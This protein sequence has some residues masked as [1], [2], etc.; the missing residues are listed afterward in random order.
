MNKYYKYFKAFIITL[1]SILVLNLFVSILYY[2][3]IFNNKELN[4]TNLIITS[5][6]MLIGGIYIGN[7]TNK[8]GYLEGLKVGIISIIIFLIISYLAFDKVINIK[9]II[10]YFILLISSVLGS[11][12]GINKKKN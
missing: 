4:Y 12:I 1:F 10:F 6:S 5:I 8:K 3:N 7:R 2:F 11:M 9:N